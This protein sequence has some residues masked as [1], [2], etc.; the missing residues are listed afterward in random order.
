MLLFANLH[1]FL[2]LLQHEQ[3]SDEA[4]LRERLS[5]WPLERLQKEGY[6]ITD[7]AAYWLDS[8]SNRFGMGRFV[9]GFMVGPGVALPAE[10]RFE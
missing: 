3:A 6:C 8:G 4:V 2:P 7:L 1:S 9:A 10:H 5:S